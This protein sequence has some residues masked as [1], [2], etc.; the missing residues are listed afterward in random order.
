M[1]P[2]VFNAA[3]GAT[4]RMDEFR[5]VNTVGFEW[6]PGSAQAII[7]ERERGYQKINLYLYDPVTRKKICCILKVVPPTSTI[8]ITG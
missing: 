7:Y 2:V 5:N 4:H 6:I 8:L 1:T 3:T